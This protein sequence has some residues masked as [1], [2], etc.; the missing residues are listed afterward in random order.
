MH[1]ALRAAL[2]RHALL[3][4]TTFVSIFNHTTKSR[5][6]HHYCEVSGA[7]SL[8]IEERD[9]FVLGVCFPNDKIKSLIALT[10]GDTSGDC[11]KEVSLPTSTAALCPP[12][13]AATSFT[14][15]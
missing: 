9:L 8:R 6:K 12:P 11:L 13:A 2:P 3:L 4:I 15:C 1:N 10:E 5:G 7:K 14:L